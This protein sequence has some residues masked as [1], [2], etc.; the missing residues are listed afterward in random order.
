MPQITYQE[1]V[2]N[3]PFGLA[4][5]NAPGSPYAAAFARGV[6]THLNLAVAPQIFNAQPQQFL[7]LQYLMSFGLGE[8]SNVDEDIWHEQ[9]W[10]R[11]PI[12]VAAGGFAGVAANPGATVTGTINIADSSIQNVFPRQK[13]N[14]RGSDGVATQA[15][16]MSVDSTPG[17]ANIVV[18]SMNSRPLAPA[19]AGALLTNGMTVGSD[20]G[21]AFSQP[22]RIQTVQRSNLLEKIGPEQKIWN[23]IE[24]IKWKKM[25]QT[26]YMEADMLDK[27]T[28][29]KTSLSQRIWFGEYG[30]SL[31]AAGEITKFTQ[32][33][34]PA[35]QQN[36]GVSLTSTTATV[37]DDMIDAVFATNFGAINNRRVVFGTPE[38]LYKLNIKQKAEFVRYS[39]G[40]KIWDMDFEEWRV[41]GQTLTLV[42]C[43]IWNDPASFPVEFANRLV[44]LQENNIKVLGTPGIPMIKQDLVSQSRTN[45]TPMEIYDFERY[46]CEGF[47]GTRTQNAAANVICDLND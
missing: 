37:W 20:G 47:V 3:A 43:Q 17:A 40:D 18:R 22:T 1:N 12:T 42:P 33:I 29:L 35:I 30:E 6:T 39:Y 31:N 16:V 19:A 9:V 28:Q 8:A 7:D 32:G 23:T 44:I 15:I 24:R 2:N 45:I 21:S 38:T 26:N 14:Y 5:T 27:L 25:Q 36:G 34:V 10:S 4:N 13:I 41:G 11:N 46:L